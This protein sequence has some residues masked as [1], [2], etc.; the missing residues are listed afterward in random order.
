[1]MSAAVSRKS[2]FQLHGVTFFIINIISFPVF[3]I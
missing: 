1:M 3:S 2:C